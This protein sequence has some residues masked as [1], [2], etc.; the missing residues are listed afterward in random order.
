MAGRAMLDFVPLAI[1]AVLREHNSVLQW[2]QT[3]AP[4]V[5]LLEPDGWFDVGHGITG[6]AY[7]EDHMWI[8]TVVQTGSFLWSPAP[9]A[10]RHAL[11][12]LAFSRHKRPDFLHIVV[13]PRL[14]TSLW[15]KRLFKLAD[16]VV[17]I[18]A[19]ARAFWPTSMHEPLILG[20]VLPLVSFPPWQLRR[21][22]EVLD[23]EGKLREVWKTPH[24]D[25]RSLLCQLL[26]L[27]RRVA[28]L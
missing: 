18:P 27:S 22:T 26:K 10:G 7:N 19:G 13:C 3:W 11:E 21:T 14:F 2:C 20:V 1:P 12:Q 8:P 6:G 5:R 23:L 24:G 9:A 25:E 17:E 16:C 28:P 4:E 15:R